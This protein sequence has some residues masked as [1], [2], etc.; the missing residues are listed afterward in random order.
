[1]APSA[2]SKFSETF[3][4][5]SDAF[6]LKPRPIRAPAS[7]PRSLSIKDSCSYLSPAHTSVLFLLRI[8]RTHM[9]PCVPSE[10]LRVLPSTIPSYAPAK[11]TSSESSVSFLHNVSVSTSSPS[12]LIMF[13]ARLRLFTP[14]VAIIDFTEFIP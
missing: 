7:G 8:L 11:N 3:N 10:F 12:P 9:A 2:F 1:M 5:F 6:L 13:D 14:V 4:D